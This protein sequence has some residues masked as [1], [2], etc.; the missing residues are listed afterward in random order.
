MSVNPNEWLSAAE[1]IFNKA[2]GFGIVLLVLSGTYWLFYRAAFITPSNAT[3]LA[4]DV[5]QIVA[6]LSLALFIVGVIIWIYRL[7]FALIRWPFSWIAKR[8]QRRSEYINLSRN[9]RLLKR[10]SQ[11]VFLHY[12]EHD[13]GRFRSPGNTPYIK[14]LTEA[15][16]I[17]A[18][19]VQDRAY[20]ISH[21]G[22]FMTVT[23][24]ANTKSM[25]KM[26]R[27]HLLNQGIPINDAA[28][29][30]QLLSNI[31]TTNRLSP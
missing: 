16:L 10:V 21:P 2:M 27:E 22:E 30:G 18:V 13:D 5:S 6:V 3:K 26:V 28:A 24:P 4:F 11:V 31:A 19:D 12:L 29:F 7:V 14:E 23:P 17:W 20:G 8:C 25:K 1:N 15:G 9:Y